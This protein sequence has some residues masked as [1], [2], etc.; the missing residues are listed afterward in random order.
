MALVKLSR[1]IDFSEDIMPICLPE[2]KHFPDETGKVYVAGWGSVADKQCT[3]G[4]YGPDPYTLCAPRLTYNGK[5]K[6]GCTTIPSPSSNDILCQQLIKSKNLIRFPEEGYTHT[7]IVD[8]KEKLLTTCYNFP[9]NNTGPYGWCAT[10]QKQTMP[11]QTPGF[12]GV[13]PPNNNETLWSPTATKGWGYCE[14]QCVKNLTDRPTMLQEVELELLTI[15]E[16]QKMGKSMNVS[17]NFERCAA[18]Q[19]TKFSFFVGLCVKLPRWKPRLLGN[20]C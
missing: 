5:N 20:S 17:T 10:C 15:K 18:K 11:G 14:K 2:S 1:E 6:S 19:V 8:D 7:E 3:T 4:K 12:C 16:C 9:M 13:F